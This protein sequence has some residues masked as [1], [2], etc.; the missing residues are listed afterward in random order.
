MPRPLP[1]SAPT[2]PGAIL[3]LIRTGQAVTRNELIEATGLGRSTIIQ[4]VNLLLESGLLVERS[5]HARSNGGRPPTPLAINE[6]AGI[7]LA[8]DLGARHGRLAIC[9]LAG[10]SLTEVE[11]RLDIATG[12]EPVL[13]W[14]T[15][16]FERLLADTDRSA[17]HVLAIGLGVPGPVD[18][19]A[20][21][22]VNPPIMPGWDGY[23]VADVLSAHFSAPALLDND[24]NIM[25]LGEHHAQLPDVDQV[26]FIKVATGIGAGVIVDGHVVR[27]NHGAAGDIGHIRSYTQ[28]DVLCTCGN[29][30]C[31][32]AL[33]SGSAIARKLGEEGLDA[34][35]SVDI[36]ELV[37]RGDT[38]ATHHVR[39]AG[40]IL[41][42]ALASLVSILAPNAL[43]IGGEMAGAEEPLLAG[44]RS[45]VYERSRPL[46]TR[47][48][49][50]VTSR[51]GERAGI[52]GAATMAANHA[53]SPARVDELIAVRTGASR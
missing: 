2:S 52:I 45:A 11:D 48:L 12:P 24:V 1:S 19:D 15:A 3:Q 26:V 9:N 20:G 16:T 13:A 18:H 4:R 31:V 36:V 35:T 32:G 22:P 23:P 10:A 39:E 6:S 44:I 8:A 27:G 25:A 49:Q 50:I 46:A 28:S 53:L 7:V 5:T 47:E 17:S 34:R 14:V 33:A 41:G 51:L 42:E 30:G 37:Q 40:R 43:I 29:R 21:R 38:I